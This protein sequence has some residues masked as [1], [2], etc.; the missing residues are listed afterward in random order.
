MVQSLDSR[1]LKFAL[2]EILQ[3]D[4]LYNKPQ[5]IFHQIVLTICNV[6]E[7]NYYT[8]LLCFISNICSKK[9]TGI[10]ISDFQ[11]CCLKVLLN[12][13]ILGRPQAGQDLMF[14]IQGQRI[15]CGLFYGL[16]RKVT[17][18]SIEYYRSI[19]VAEN[20]TDCP[21]K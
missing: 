7:Q 1:R 18:S 5:L 2:F 15:C 3:N 16:P 11:G 9:E 12:F 20:F 17:K 14:R 19:Y 21:K 6:F 4:I 10:Q 8:Y 13:L